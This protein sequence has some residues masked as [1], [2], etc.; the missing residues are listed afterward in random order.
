MQPS[1][2]LLHQHIG[3][4]LMSSLEQICLFLLALK[5]SID[6]QSDNVDLPIV[7]FFHHQH[8]A[9]VGIIDHQIDELSN[10]Q[11]KPD[12]LAN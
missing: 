9:P 7:R 6:K 1:T 12:S 11:H 4:G 3:I 8:E 5:I 10:D 2:V